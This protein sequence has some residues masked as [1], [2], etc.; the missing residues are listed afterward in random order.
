[1][2][3]AVCAQTL[4][5]GAKLRGWEVEG[6]SGVHG[7]A[8]V[9]AVC[10]EETAEPAFFQEYFPAGPGVRHTN[11][12]V[13]PRAGA[14]G[15][16]FL[17][18]RETFLMQGATLAGLCAARPVPHLPRVRSVFMEQGT[19]YMLMDRY[20]GTPLT[21]ELDLKHLLPEERLITLFRPLAL[22]LGQLHEAGVCHL[23]I[24][25]AVIMRQ[26]KRLLLTGFA[27][28]MAP[29]GWED[30]PGTA[31]CAIELLVPVASTGPWSDVYSLGAVLYHCMTG[32]P[33][34][35]AIARLGPIDWPEGCLQTYSAEF[36]GAVAAALACVPADRPQSM[37]D[38]C[39]AWPSVPLPQDPAPAR[40][41]PEAGPGSCSAS[42]QTVAWLPVRA[43]DEAHDL[44]PLAPIGP[45]GGSS[46][47]E[48]SARARRFFM[49]WLAGAAA[50]GGI[51]LAVVMGRGLFSLEGDGGDAQSMAPGFWPVSTAGSE[52]SAPLLLLEKEVAAAREAAQHVAAQVAEA[53]RLDWPAEQ[54]G[55]L[56]KAERRAAA[57]VAELEA[58]H[59]APDAARPAPE[60]R[61]FAAVLEQQRQSIRAAVQE[62][63]AISASA[64]AA[65]AGQLVSN[66]DAN[67]QLLETLLAQDKRPEPTLLLGTTAS[68]HALLGAANERLQRATRAAAPADPVFASRQLAEIAS[69]YE[70][71]RARSVAIREA[72]RIGREHAAA[73][74][75]EQRTASRERGQFSA[76]LASAH[77]AVAELE[78]TMQA[79]GGADGSTLPRQLA[80]EAALRVAEAR[81]RLSGLE[82]IVLE[83]PDLRG[84]RL[85]AALVE[86]RET[87]KTLRSLLLEARGQA[88]LV[89]TP[90]QNPEVN[91][92]VRRAD[93]RL[94]RNNRRYGDLQKLVAQL[95]GM[96]PL[97]G[98]D[99]VGRQN[100]GKVYRDLMNQAS[101]RDRLAKA[102]T[103]AEAKALYEK[104]M[105]Q[106]AKVDRDLDRMLRAVSKAGRL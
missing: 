50:A 5:A 66:G 62:A 26:N 46:G 93:S 63:W 88:S 11:G 34:M 94:A 23:R 57:A 24:N 8:I 36:R 4:P 19:A 60:G 25:P 41:A 80:R 40:A 58:L 83:T 69:A 35:E 54:I 51:V 101:A 43:D 70:D 61:S 20:G 104:F 18:G 32:R 44:T 74:E 71:V 3:A 97:K 10:H 55:A 2:T 86:V 65:S 47:E 27:G 98:G 91:K 30:D 29:R 73:R 106:H 72:L 90:E 37:K 76:A 33:P 81:R 22:A 28:G 89:N 95:G 16:Q 103:A 75:A 100:M 105:A 38:W 39:A 78:Q 79:A 87:E 53:E 52:L 12:S 21:T 56:R 68:A 15:E 99:A 82:H 13:G 17:T 7:D 59:A 31:Y 77:R 67:Y 42:V 96:I 48:G 14:A 9:Y 85:Q 49:P 102:K 84:E 64:Y 45:M 1:M 92:L 6:V